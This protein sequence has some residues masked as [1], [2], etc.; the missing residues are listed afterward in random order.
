MHN[1]KEMGLSDSL[2]QAITEMGFE[3]PTP[4]Q[5]ET[6]P[7]L[8]N[9]TQDLVGL[10]QTG[11]G[12]TAAF[13]LPIID[14]I[15][16]GDKPQ[17]LI[18]CPTRELCLQISKDVNDFTKHREAV[19]ITSVYG[20]T[21]IKGQI[22]ALKQKPQ[23]IAGTPGRV[24]DLINRK[25]LD[26]SGIQKLVLDEADE[27][28]SMGFKEELDAIFEQIPN[29]RQT[30]LF[31][32]TMPKEIQRIA[33][34]FM[35]NPKEISV[36]KKNEGAE[37]VQ[38]EYCLVWPKDRFK[39][40]Q[41]LV[42]YNPDMYAIVFCRT[43]NETR[44]VADQLMKE[45][46]RTEAL[47]GDLSQAQRDQ[48]MQSF[49]DQH[50]KLLVATDVAARGLDVNN[51]THV[52]H[53][54]LPEDPELYIHRSGRTGRA[55]K[56]GTSISLVTPRERAQLSRIGQVVGK[57]INYIKI[58][59]TS[60]VAQRRIENFLQRVSEAPAETDWVS[61]L[62]DIKAELL[63]LSK[64]TLVNKFLAVELEQYLTAAEDDRDLNAK[65]KKRR[66]SESPDTSRPNKN[67]YAKLFLNL[68]KEHELTKKALID[69][70]NQQFPREKVDIGT[71][72]L[73]D[74]V[75]FFEIDHRY[76]QSLLKA[77]RDKDKAF[78]GRT[79]NVELARDK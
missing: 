45:G 5:Q 32:A 3:E 14:Q 20:G 42:D 75:S 52:V 44:I 57:S 25:Q 26:L 21:D 59:D 35:D 29:E 63:A 55:G 1:F 7:F 11:T 76:Q 33:N 77:F 73:L 79:V 12:K 13:G 50:I 60:S 74:R 38:H 65:P 51:L 28:L 64:E 37:N 48:V 16:G 15:Q 41:R 36:G 58:P 27:M 47:N 70:I 71:I 30:L 22:K 56:S 24:L 49:R 18:L 6:I 53:Y 62:D 31:S 69:M 9:Q 4:I 17:V 2:L 67:G 19:S 23:I 39:A 40:L 43:K 10:A 72:K 68:G 54:N 8:L 46:Y 78:N 34:K 61:N 66:Q